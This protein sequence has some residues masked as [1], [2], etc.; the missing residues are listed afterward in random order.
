LIKAKKDL[1]LYVRVA[2]AL[3]LAEQLQKDAT[4]AVRE[5]EV[6]KKHID[7]RLDE[8]LRSYERDYD[9]MVQ[10]KVDNA[11]YQGFNEG[12]EAGID[13]GERKAKIKIMEEQ[14]KERK[15]KEEMLRKNSTEV[16]S[17]RL[18]N[19][20]QPR[21]VGINTTYVDKPVKSN[22]TQRKVLFL[23]ISSSHSSS[24]I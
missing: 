24:C 4:Q 8:W 21:I 7:Y 22:H 2:E 15:E 13:E 1:E 12:Y 14:E 18:V 6:A 11:K 9:Q 20:G 19:V 5:L 17:K 16:L 3:R 23:F 10:R